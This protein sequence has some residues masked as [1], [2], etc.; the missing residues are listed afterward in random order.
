M[1]ETAVIGLRPH[2]YWTAVVVLAGPA[3]APRVLERRRMV[4]ADGAER[5]VYHR[6][7]KLDLAAGRGLIEAVRGRTESNAKRGFVDLLGTLERTGAAAALAVVP[8]GRQTPLDDLQAVLRSHALMNA[9]E[10]HFSREVLAGAFRRLGLQVARPSEHELGAQLA[11]RLGLDEEML[12]A[13]LR[14]MGAALGP[15]W[16]QDQKLAAQAA[17][18]HL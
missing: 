10:G 4:F 12:E 5:F 1:P 8:L 11:G 3:H 13:R 14:D 18:L 16:G 2:S 6:A 15:P 17:W 7:E 9:A